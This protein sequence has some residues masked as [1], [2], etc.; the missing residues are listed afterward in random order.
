MA[1]L[2]DRFGRKI[3]YIRISLTDRCNMR[4]FYCM[5]FG[6]NEFTHGDEA[7]NAHELTRIVAAMAKRGLRKVR[8]TGGEPLLRTD[9][10]E[11]A[12]GIA[13]VDGIE[14][15]AISTNALLLKEKALAL[16]TAGVRRANISLDSLD[17]VK[18]AKVTGSSLHKR[19]LS[20]IHAAL[21]AGF[22]PVKINIVALPDLDRHELE[23]FVTWA[24]HLG[25]HLR[26]I[27]E[28]PFGG[29]HGRGPDNSR[30]RALIEEFT[31]PLEA[32]PHDPLANLLPPYR[33]PGESWQITFIS[34]M[35][36]PFCA[37]CNRVRLSAKG[38]LKLCL[39]EDLGIDL[40]PILQRSAS[41]DELGEAIADSI[42]FD[43]PERHHFNDPDF[44][45]AGR[46]MARIGG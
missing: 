27:E 30:I 23:M 25:L 1:A 28:M 42:Y 2:K 20:G 39:D 35:S 7:L 37:G 18:F 15:L 17:P 6:S 41:I 26:F 31:G 29:V 21:E 46:I 33:I 5:P 12:V 8:L 14:D 38:F 19:V 45:R 4:C 24:S 16:K 13:A 11:I 43:K 22:A 10:V 3:E 36:G 9:I 32:L 40:K 34:P 44:D